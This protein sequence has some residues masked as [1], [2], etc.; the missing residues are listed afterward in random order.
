[1]KIEMTVIENLCEISNIKFKKK[2]KHLSRLYGHWTVTLPFTLLASY[3]H[4]PLNLWF[5]I[6]VWH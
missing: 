2:K 1:M 5:R 3:T 6:C 4:I